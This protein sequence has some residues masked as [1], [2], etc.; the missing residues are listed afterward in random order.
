M[1]AQN[2]FSAN[3]EKKNDITKLSIKNP[4]LQIKSLIPPSFTPLYK[5]TKKEKREKRIF[6]SSEKSCNFVERIKIGNCNCR[7]SLKHILW[8]NDGRND[9]ITYGKEI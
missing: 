8:C 6:V 7:D 4:I 3:I 9:I 5:Y 2:I 1:A